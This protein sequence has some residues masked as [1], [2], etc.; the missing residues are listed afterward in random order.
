MS[1]NLSPATQ[2]LITTAEASAS[3]AAVAAGTVAGDQ[4]TLASTQQQL[5]SDQASALTAAKQAYTDGV[6][7]VLAVCQELG[8]PTPTFPPAPT[9]V[10]AAKPAGRR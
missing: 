3:A 9:A 4:S 7:A 8:L 2:A 10:P 5:A 1:A 6:A